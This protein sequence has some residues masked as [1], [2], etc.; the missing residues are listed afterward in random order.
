MRSGE[1]EV[2]THELDFLRSPHDE[3]HP[4]KSVDAQ[5]EQAHVTKSL[6]T[7][8]GLLLFEILKTSL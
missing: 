1:I 5:Y 7:L 3:L 2:F 8:K 6:N 4:D